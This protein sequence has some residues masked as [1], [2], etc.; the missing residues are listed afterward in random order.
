MCLSSKLRNGGHL[1]AMAELACTLSGHQWT[2]GNGI[3]MAGRIC[4][5]KE[6]WTWILRCNFSFRIAQKI[7]DP[8]WQILIKSSRN[9]RAHAFLL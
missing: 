9:Q 3:R 1:R 6:K 5:W 8:A 4:E 7:S 2:S